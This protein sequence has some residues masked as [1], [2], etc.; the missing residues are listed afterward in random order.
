MPSRDKSSSS[1]S[2]SRANTP[3]IAASLNA[4]SAVS[5]LRYRLNSRSWLSPGC[6]RSNCSSKPSVAALAFSSIG[7][8]T[9]AAILTG[10]RCGFAPAVILERMSPS[11]SQFT[12]ARLGACYPFGAGD[13]RAS[14]RR[15]RDATFRARR[16][17]FLTVSYR[18]TAWHEPPAAAGYVSTPTGAGA[19][20]VAPFG[21][22]SLNDNRGQLDFH[23]CEQL[24][25]FLHALQSPSKSL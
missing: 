12:F 11:V 19:S 1:P 20:F 6:S 13:F 23:R 25:L 4:G 18:L 9:F 22:Q 17:N 16:R 8:S 15:R 5:R 3:R 21:K 14:D 24:H 7:A 10:L 2:H